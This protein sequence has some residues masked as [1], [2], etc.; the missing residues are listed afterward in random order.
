MTH[1]QVRSLGNGRGV[2]SRRMLVGSEDACNHGCGPLRVYS[3]NDSAFDEIGATG[4]PWWPGD[5]SCS[6]ASFHGAGER[7]VC[8][9]RFCQTPIGRALPQLLRLLPHSVGCACCQE[10]DAVRRYRP[11][12]ADDTPAASPSER[13]ACSAAT[14]WGEFVSMPTAAGAGKLPVATG[15]GNLGTPCPRMHRDTARSL[16]I[17]CGLTCVAGA[18]EP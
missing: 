15:S 7:D 5:G 14:T 18:D 4:D 13:H 8:R 6:D 9:S 12:C 2:A 1:G 11:V 10:R 16:P 17:S 3:D